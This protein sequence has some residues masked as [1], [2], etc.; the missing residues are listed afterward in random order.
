MKVYEGGTDR[1][2]KDKKVKLLIYIFQKRD[3]IRRKC[4]FHQS[5]IK[6][7]RDTQTKSNNRLPITK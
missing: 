5:L 3:A 6:I 2:F 4:V 1:I 7:E